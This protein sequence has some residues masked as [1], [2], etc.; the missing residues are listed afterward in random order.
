MPPAI[1]VTETAD[2]A[3]VNEEVFGPLLVVMPFDSEAEAVRLA[4]DSEYGLAAC[5]WTSNLKRAHRLAS[6][7]EAGQIYVNEYF[8]GGV[9]T[10]FGG[11]KKSGYGREKGMEA[12]REYTHLKCVT[13]R[14]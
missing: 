2:S 12:L 1:F 5:I 9:E 3:I 8:A 7:I 10:P 14:L 6:A 4:N 13:M 11:H